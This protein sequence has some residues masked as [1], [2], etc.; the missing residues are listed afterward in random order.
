[1]FP[2]P[3]EKLGEGA[4]LC[5]DNAATLALCALDVFENHSAIA[6]FL[7]ILAFEEVGKG[8]ALIKKYEKGDGLTEEEWKQLSK[9][10]DA[11]KRKLR[12]V[13]TALIDPYSVL[14]PHELSVKLE[15]IKEFE[16][17]AND[18]SEQIHKLKLDYL[19]VDW[20]EKENRWL[21][22]NERKTYDLVM[23]TERLQAAITL[24]SK[25]L[26]ESHIDA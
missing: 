6:S 9:Y 15:E 8:I 19:Y 22:P 26:K 25:K 14:S 4:K 23:V 2:I 10:R 7:T 17:I 11:H 21:S 18:I 16:P 3:C 1:L 20:D 12:I 24:L 5:R 13:H